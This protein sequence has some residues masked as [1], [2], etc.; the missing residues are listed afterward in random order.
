MPDFSTL[1]DADLVSK[2]QNDNLAAFDELVRRHQ[3]M[4]TRSLFRFCP[5]QSEL[6]DLVQE[7]FIKA[8][9]KIH[10]WKPSAPFD[11]W[12]RKI[13]F[14]TGHDY[15]RRNGRNPVAIADK[16]GE[17]NEISLS[18]LEAKTDEYNNMQNTEHVQLLLSELS[19]DDRLLITLQ[20][21][22]ELSLAEIGKQIGWSLAKTKVKSFRAR[23]K[24]KQILIRHGITEY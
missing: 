19:P 21:L 15:F 23:K 16:M 6:E 7:T 18:N 10:T 14:N 12:L 3:Q 22:E 24:L 9:R 8:F 13:A 4:I 1:N 17:A 5:H 11:H 2:T 20:Y